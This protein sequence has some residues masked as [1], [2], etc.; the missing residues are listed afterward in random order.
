MSSQNTEKLE[1][2]YQAGIVAFERG[3]YRQA[4]QHLEV[5][6]ALVDRNSRLGGEVLIWLVTAYEAS[7]KL[8]EARAL[9]QQLEC[10]PDLETRKQGK[11]L[12]YILQAP[13]LT[14]RPEWLTQIPDLTVLEEGDEKYRRGSANG[15]NS[16]KLPKEP[17]PIETKGVN[18]Q[19]N[20][21]IWVALVAAALV[22]SG[23][24][25][26]KF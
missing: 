5:A 26:L 16:Q 9:C 2:A 24:V 18:T 10:H 1:I 15:N 12:L 14:R 17:E 13:Q 21:F 22:L 6:S 11:R 7:G 8:T 4:V 25:W 20:L 19:D 3:E 23:L